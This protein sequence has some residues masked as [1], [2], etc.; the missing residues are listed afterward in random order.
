M[1]TIPS[2]RIGFIEILG[3]VATKTEDCPA[4]ARGSDRPSRPST[5]RGDI[6]KKSFQRRRTINQNAD[7]GRPSLTPAAAHTDTRSI[8]FCRMREHGSP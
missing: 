2:S 3:G 5:R 4:R 7:H 6:A 8:R 1:G